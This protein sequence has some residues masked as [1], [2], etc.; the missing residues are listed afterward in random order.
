MIAETAISE[1]N[2]MRQWAGWMVGAMVMGVVVA[3]AQ[4]PATPPAQ[5]LNLTNNAWTTPELPMKIVGPIHYVGTKDLAAYLITTPAGH[6]LLDG[7]VPSMAG[8]I[9]KSIRAL[10]F[11]PED[12]KI[13]LTSQAHFDHV[14]TL[15]H[16]KKLTGASVR[17][18]QGDEGIVAD[19][20]K[21][22]YLLGPRTEAHFE[23]VTV[24]VVL[25]DGDTIALGNVSLKALRTPGH[26]PGCATYTTTVTDGGRTYT[27][28]FPGSTTVNP[29][30]RLVKNPSYPGIADDFRRTFER[31]ASLKPDIFLG[32][33]ASFFDLEG[34][35]AKAKTEGPKA[36]VDPDGYRRL[37]AQ[38]RE[39]F[40]AAVKA[41]GQ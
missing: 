28:V 20:G 7:A 4:Q 10:G 30:T 15:A 41:E 11:K 31:L 26:T 12:I 8:E 34:K 16:F 35:R 22:D 39:Q 3:S 2:T 23:P 25:K 17:I 40:D 5:Q 36:F 14:G 29:G 9:E 37:H 1:E 33:H 38:K 13:L 19:G 18:M 32:A 27:V 24:D 21:S 6:I